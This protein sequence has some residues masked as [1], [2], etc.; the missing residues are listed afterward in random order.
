MAGGDWKDMYQ[1]SF[2]GD[3]DLVK[4]HIK[5]GVDPN[6]QHPEVLSTPLVAAVLNGHTEVAKFLISNGA[7]PRLVS[8]LDGMNGIEAAR[9]RNNVE[10]LRYLGE[11]AP[12]FKPSLLSRW[13]AVLRG[14]R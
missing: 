13:L 11:P 12:E 1:A 3:L 9:S 2:N 14:P 7:D 6:Y 4:Y 10:L 8:M 5:N